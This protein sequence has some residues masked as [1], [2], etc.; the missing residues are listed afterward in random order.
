MHLHHLSEENTIPIQK[1]QFQS[2]RA[3]RCSETSYSVSPYIVVDHLSV[4]TF[5]HSSN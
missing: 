5:C 3:T 4:R 2:V 1:N